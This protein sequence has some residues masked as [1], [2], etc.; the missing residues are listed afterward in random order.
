MKW[1]GDEVSASFVGVVAC[2]SSCVLESLAAWR[3][4]R[5]G[6]APGHGKPLPF[7]DGRENQVSGCDSSSCSES[8][9]KSGDLTNIIQSRKTCSIVSFCAYVK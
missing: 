5:V 8:R 9:L 6:I 2:L 1:E 3:C 7:L 4:S